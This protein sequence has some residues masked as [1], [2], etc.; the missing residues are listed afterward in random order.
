M[1]AGRMI[2]NTTKIVVDENCFTTI[3]SHFRDG[4]NENW[5]WLRFATLKADDIGLTYEWELPRNV[6]QQ[7][8]QNHN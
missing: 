6:N 5:A 2:S 8:S 7:L 1:D 3:P 4:E